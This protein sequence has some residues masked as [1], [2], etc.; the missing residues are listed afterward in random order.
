MPY[1]D[2]TA[3]SAQMFTIVDARLVFDSA[4]VDLPRGIV[5][6]I[7]RARALH[8]LPPPPPPPPG[9][10]ARAGGGVTTDLLLCACA[11]SERGQEQDPVDADS[12]P[13]TRPN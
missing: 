2:A 5:A 6:P 12:T 7:P 11:E 8:A 4:F 1:A 13:D 3:T 9:G 10:T